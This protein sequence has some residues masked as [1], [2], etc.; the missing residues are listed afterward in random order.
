MK[1]V[2]LA[3]PIT[4]CSFEGAND[5]R[6]EVSKRLASGIEAYSPIRGKTFL[7]G[8]TEIGHEY[9]EHLMSSGRAIT[10]RDRNDTFTADALLVNLLG[11]TRVSV[12]TMIELGWADRG[13]TPI[14]LAME[15]DNPHQHPMVKDVAGWIVP[16]LEDA[17]KVVN[18]LLTPGV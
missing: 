10:V 2:Y 4:G 11:A 6:V 1:R 12:G 16:T 15:A 5:W 13:R 17:I 14:V 9:P 18:L 8:M 3:G 7:E